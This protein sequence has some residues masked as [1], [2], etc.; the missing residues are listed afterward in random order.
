MAGEDMAHPLRDRAG[1]AIG[2]ATRR[3]EWRTL[4]WLP[5][6]EISEDGDIRHTTKKATRPA[7]YVVK[8]CVNGQGYLK[9][10]LSTPTG[11]RQLAI[12][13][14]VCEAFHGPQPSPDAFHVAHG[15]GNPLN[16]HY[17]NLRWATCKDNLAD[18][19]RHGTHPNG[20]RNPRARLTWDDVRS[21][22]RRFVGDRGEV[23]A[24]AREYGVS[25]GAMQAVCNG[26][27]WH[28]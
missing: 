22:R 12:H 18:R 26:S 4:D 20:E 10:K 7:G 19:R 15:D 5:G 21:I 14:L 6:Y 23:A 9:A 16:N 3:K 8:G 25:H 17:T 11:K 1:A 24:L 13:R 2:Q 27:H 28:E